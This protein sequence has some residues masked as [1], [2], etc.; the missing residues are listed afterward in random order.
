MAPFSSYTKVWHASSYPAIS[1][2]RPELSLAGKTAILTGGG[3]GIGLAIAQ[4]LAAAGVSRLA[5]MGRR[6]EVLAKAAAEIYDLVGDKVQ[7]LAVSTDISN[8]AQVD[9]AFSRISGE[10]HSKP[11]DILVHCAGQFS[12]IR[13]LGTEIAEEWDAT[14]NVN[15]KGAYF[16]V[17]AFIAKAARNATVINVTSAIA[18][19]LHP[20]FV[21]YAATKL[22][23][24]QIMRYAAADNPQMHF[25]DV[26]PGQVTETD[27]AGL[28]PTRLPHID[29]GNNAQILCGLFKSC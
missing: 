10:F 16:V 28:L 11:L 6:A 3:S 18:H 9:E 13:P 20:G 4:S 23:G 14:L 1:P 12:G 2:I 27:M 8:K 17:A 5:I 15:V 29:D 7:V 22:A 26:H 19:V 21:S 25:V 24:A